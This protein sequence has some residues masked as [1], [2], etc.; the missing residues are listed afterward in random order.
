MEPSVLLSSLLMQP[1][2]LLL[3]FAGAVTRNEIAE[4]TGALITALALTLFVFRLPLYRYFRRKWRRNTGNKTAANEK[5]MLRSKNAGKGNE[6]FLSL[7]LLL[8]IPVLLAAVQLLT[9]HELFSVQLGPIWNLN[10]PDGLL[11]IGDITI[12]VLPMIAALLFLAAGMFSVRRAPWPAKVLFPLVACGAGIFLYEKASSI[13]LCWG[14]SNLMLTA[15]GVLPIRS[16]TPRRIFQNST[17]LRKK[18]SPVSML[19]SAGLFTILTGL[20][21][22]SAALVSSPAEFLES[23][24]A[25]NP[26]WYVLHSFLTAAGF[27]FIWYQAFYRLS[28][29]RTKKALELVAWVICGLMLINYLFFRKDLG[30]ISA[31]LQYERLPVFSKKQIAVN[32][33]VLLISAAALAFIMIREDVLT[34]TVSVM[35][36]LALGGMSARNIWISAQTIRESFQQ[37]EQSEKASFQIPLSRSG[38]NVIVLMLDR[39]IGVYMPSVLV[40][41][42]ELASLFSGFVYYPNTVSHGAFTNLGMPGLFGGYEYTPAAMNQRDQEPLGEKHNEA[43]KVM[44]TLFSENGYRVTVCNPTYA[45]YRSTTDLTIFDDLQNTSAYVTSR[46]YNAEVS[47]Q[48][49]YTTG[50]RNYFCY[51]LSETVPL[52]MYSCF[53]DAG[54]YRRMGVGQDTQVQKSVSLASGI[55]SAFTKQYII[56][57]KLVDLTEI[58]DSPGDTF[59]MMVNKTTHNP[60]LLSEPDYQPALSVNNEAY[61]REHANRF[62]EIPDP[63][64]VTQPMQMGHYHALMASL[65]RIG[66]WLNYLKENDLYDNTRIILAADHGSEMWQEGMQL[67]TGEDLY[68][69]NPL[70]LVKDFNAEGELKTDTTFMT[71]ADVPTIATRDVIPAPVINPYTGKEINGEIDKQEPQQVSTSHNWKVKENN[72]NRFLPADWFSVHDNLFDLS[73]WEHLGVY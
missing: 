35:L 18:A 52:L 55:S 8:E 67:S 54:N 73:N 19:L 21:I 13:A 15:V 10:A 45:G 49:A 70:L 17:F 7:P 57:Q 56:L 12:H 22:P 71:N 60:M 29:R 27:S 41:K 65:L 34:K 46:I 4:G 9:D 1:V 26:L 32:T 5:T 51:G 68:Y 31:S 36:I 39:A 44:P 25:V 64:E 72:G 6:F 66:E 48:E 23:S 11:R 40:E 16:K 30:T 47:Q 53:Y 42:P 37:M 62:T 28:P 33:L 61:D 38:K 2:K 3:E 59:L 50:I 24:Q 58:S 14:L 63:I 43:L 20:L 69:Y